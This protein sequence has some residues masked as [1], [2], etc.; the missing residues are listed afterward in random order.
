MEDGG[1]RVGVS[2]MKF[3]KWASQPKIL[4]VKIFLI[5]FKS[6]LI[7]LNWLTEIFHQKT[8]VKL[9]VAMYLNLKFE[10]ILIYNAAM[11]N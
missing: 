1:L 10:L 11:D 4:S 6:V 9:L 8:Y 5:I 7:D 3:W 2:D